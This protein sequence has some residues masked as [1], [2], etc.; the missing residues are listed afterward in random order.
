VFDSS[1]R[2]IFGG[3]T[4]ESRLRAPGKFCDGCACVDC[5]NTEENLAE[6]HK[7]R[8]KVN[9]KNPHAFQDKKVRHEPGCLGNE[10]AAH[11]A[12]DLCSQVTFY[13]R[14]AESNRGKRLQLLEVAVSQGLLRVLCGG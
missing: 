6:V 11:T 2:F 12:I 13:D 10:S 3:A 9:V 5:G 14:S 7:R 1:V 8:H 4:F